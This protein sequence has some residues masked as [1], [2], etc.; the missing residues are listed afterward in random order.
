MLKNYLKTTLRN[1]LK[2]K[3]FSLINVFG[4]AAGLAITILI[5][6]H[7]QAEMSYDNVHTQRDKIYR[8]LRKSEVSDKGYLI[9]ITSGPY[10]PALRND[11]P[12]SIKD[13]VR[14]LP[15]DGLATYD[16]R[17]FMEKKFFFADENFFKVFSF[18]LAKGDPARVLA[19]PNAVVITPEIA[20]KYFGEGEPIGKTIRMDDE[21]D[22][23]VTGVM[24]HRLGRSHLDFDFMASLKT[25]EKEEWLHGWWNNILL[26]YVLIDNPKEANRVEAQ[27]PGFIDKYLGEDF[28]RNGKRIDL[29]LQPL[30]EIYFEKDIRYERGVRHGDKNAVYIFGAI[31]FF[32]LVIACINYMNLTTARAGR[33]A[34]EIGVRKVLG[35]HKSSLVWQFLSESFLLTS[36]AIILAVALS[37]L[38]LPRF[39]A[40]F[41][42]DLA[43]NFADP[44]LPF[45]LLGLLFVVSVL[46]GSYPAFL[47][48]SFLPIR[49]LKGRFSRQAA[50][51]HIRKGLVVFQFCISAFLIIV[52]LLIVEQLDFMRQKD[53]GF[54]DEQVVLVPMNNSEIR[55][56][57]EDFASRARQER[58]ILSVSAMSGQP[59]G[60]HDAMSFKIERKD[61][62]YRLRTVYTDF[63]YVE[64]L[65]LEIVAGRNFSKTFG[66]DKEQAVLLNETAVKLI[67][68][69]NEEALSK[70]MRHTM[71]DTSRCHV[72]GVVEDYHFSS[73]KEGI[74][75]LFI[76]MR[77]NANIFAIKVEPANIQAALASIQQHWERISPAYPFEFTFLD[78]T[79]YKLYQQEQKESKLFSIFSFISIV[80]ACLGI[81]ALASYAAEERTKEIG[82]RK[83]LGASVGSV[84]NLLSKEYVR[85]VVIA[86]LFAWPL[87]W[88]AMSQWLRDF[89]Y[90]VEIAWWVF[91][92]A[93]GLV[94][95]IALLTVSILAMK[96][97]LANPVEALRYE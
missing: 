51:T 39:N 83:V 17:A 35:A 62:N 21:Y 56:H 85:L 67:G 13:A 49:V 32:I 26:T 18:P 3:L 95:L 87:A 61:E 65:G 52:T 1:L 73:L 59:G 79:F 70:E 92:L 86:N 30:A 81:F 74:E 7:V 37:E 41:G 54:N 66:T 27:L 48:S 44:L 53:L 97:A 78:E 16:H 47:L 90:R 68:W 19:S 96:A 38:L 84:F 15:S 45:S 23:I 94:M 22:F 14:V 57:Q 5:L 60:F 40:A 31:A 71:F 64:T 76:A 89:A 55:K 9:G 69:T 34:R 77:R 2:Q 46:A 93:G 88:F 33:R 91:A 75:P 72:V 36:L 42:L 58:G 10:A 82:I 6:L 63:D 50:D 29:T 12:E 28:K 8:V 20:R 24:A 80:I 43:M 25:L 11:L 4:L